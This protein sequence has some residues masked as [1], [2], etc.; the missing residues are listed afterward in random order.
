MRVQLKVSLFFCLLLGVCIPTSGKIRISGR[1]TSTSGDPVE[2]ANVWLEKSPFSC[3]SDTAGFYS[4]EVDKAVGGLSAS[5]VGFVKQTKQISSRINCTIDFI[6]PSAGDLAEVIVTEKSERIK[7][8]ESEFTV[9][10][11]DVASL[12][13]TTVK[14]SDLV[15]RTAGVRVRAEGGLGSDFDVSL[16]GLSGSAI[17]YFIDGM[18]M[19]RRGSEVSLGN[20]PLNQ[21]ERVDIYKG[22]V[23]SYFG[24][25]AMGGVI[26]IVTKRN[27]RRFIDA[28]VSCGSFGT[29]LADLAGQIVEK[30]S[31]LLIRPSFDF[32]YSNND[33]MM[34][35]VEVWDK[36]ADKYIVTNRRRFHDAYRAY[37]GQLELGF[38]NK[39][40]AKRLFLT[41]SFSNINKEIQT[42]AVQA[43]VYGSP[44]RKSDAWSIG[45]QYAKD[46]LFLSGLNVSLNLSHTWD[47]SITVDS[48]YRKYDWNGNWIPSQRNEITGGAKSIHHY[49]RP[50]TSLKANFDYNIGSFHTINLNYSLNR[51]G[52]TRYDDLDKEYEPSKDI[53]TKHIAG[54]SYAQRL[55]DGRLQNTAFG[56]LYVEQLEICQM[57]DR[58]NEDTRE[59]KTKSYPGYG[60]G[61]RFDIFDWL[62][63]KASVEEA[64]RLPLSRELLGNGT[65]VK[66]N[67]N[68]RPETSTNLNIGLFGNLFPGSVHS[69]YYEVAGYLREVKDMIHMVTNE[70]TGLSY[71][72]N[73]S[74]VSV[75]GIEGEVSY[76]FLKR[77]HLTTNWSY[78]VSRDMNAI[79]SDGK[80]SVTY[81]NRIPNRPWLYGNT[82]ITY[83][84]PSLFFGHD[85][86]RIGYSYQYVHWFFLTWEGYG[87]LSSKSTI[88][89]QNPMN[90]YST[91]SWKN[92]RY[93]LTFEVNNIFDQTLYDNYKLQK[94]GRAFMVK[95]RLF[96][97]S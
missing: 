12:V 91:Y 81:K 74:K 36:E 20:L 84:H 92:Q 71:Y 66:A 95:F 39:S 2:F 85:S 31:G 69:L 28:S 23:P 32:S 67:L 25:D 94:P 1:V 73:I 9:N 18:P 29:Y 51:T 41:G 26:N 61:S 38:E 54:L 60:L 22:V 80:P 7:L 75:A 16:N 17:R 79:R 34:H 65:T 49:V 56:K 14:L 53:L 6:L 13:N 70:N 45:A 82:E 88:P 44:R 89:T 47:H 93:N 27:K 33:Y 35:D 43:I 55:V 77:L 21:V 37:Q 72:A 58:W 68:L 87:S 15:G 62:Q 78:S 8:R 48:V 11:I 59:S 19:E 97:E 40:W 83:I 5:A 52:N 42:G 57:T 24:T 76:H 63:A 10:T 96:F 86:L 3:L 90:I 30:S 64:V 4:L 46:S 50:F